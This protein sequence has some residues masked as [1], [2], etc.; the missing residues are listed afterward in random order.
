MK[1]QISK[2]F[3]LALAVSIMVGAFAGCSKPT[4]NEIVGSELEGVGYQST[5]GEEIGGVV[6]SY[7]ADDRIYTFGNKELGVIA[8]TLPEGMNVG[9]AS[10]ETPLSGTAWIEKNENSLWCRIV[11]SDDES[12]LEGYSAKTLGDIE[13]LVPEDKNNTWVIEKDKYTIAFI[14]TDDADEETLSLI[15]TMISTTSFN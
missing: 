7:E 13:V 15:E 4:S 8:I 12:E 10:F 11:I 9:G 6:Q 1:R 2:I 5:E 3:I 14:A